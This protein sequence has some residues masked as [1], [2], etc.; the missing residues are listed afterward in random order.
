MLLEVLI[1]TTYT[2]HGSAINLANSIYSMSGVKSVIVCQLFDL[3]SSSLKPENF[4][5]EAY[6]IY[7]VD[8][9]GLSKSRNFAIEKSSSIYGWFLD[10]DVEIDAVSLSRLLETVENQHSLAGL[11]F[12]F[13]DKVGRSRKEY[14]LV[15]FQHNLFSIMKVSS[16][17][18]VVNIDF[19][20]QNK[21]K[22]DE[23]FGLGSK[24]PSGEENIFLSDIL[25]NHGVI[26]F[27]PKTVCYHPL[28]TS[29]SSFFSNIQWRAK[30]AL[31]ARIFGFAGCF[32]ILPFA[33]KRLLG[34]QTSVMQF[35][36]G[37]KDMI[38]GFKDVH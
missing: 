19:V 3:I 38:K 35:F 28:E 9:K 18:I 36:S 23:R 17:E 32:F 2:R 14:K 6:S 5:A 13:S 29:S 21:I 25:K 15:E 33:F 4:D 8:S 37:I 1:S 12:Q 24:Y 34:N 30:G 16:I 27:I 7:F 11:T 22:L 26:K 20:K 10:D 31:L